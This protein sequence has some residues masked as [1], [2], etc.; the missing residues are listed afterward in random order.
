MPWFT[1]IETRI[2][3]F[4]QMIR[5]QQAVKAAQAPGAAALGFDEVISAINP[6]NNTVIP[7][8]ATTQWHTRLCDTCERNEQLVLTDRA[9]NDKTVTELNQAG[10][11]W[12]LEHEP[13]PPPPLPVA[14][15]APLPPIVVGWPYS[16]CIC[17]GQLAGPHGNQF[18]VRCCADKACSDHDERLIIRQ[19]N[20]AW[21]RSITLVGDEIRRAPPALRARR[22][23]HRIFRACRCGR[24]IRF[25][26]IDGNQPDVDKGP[27]VTQC[28]GCEGIVH[29]GPHVLMHQSPVAVLGLTITRRM[30]DAIDRA[31]SGIVDYPLR[32]VAV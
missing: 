28:L 8:A 18:C 31:N 2:N 21:L 5:S 15:G 17:S 1:A 13:N 26:S 16:T 20:D 24:E 30:Q 9:E 14:P 29:H 7:A 22:V 11:L 19:Q 32:R 23:Q 25:R 27:K 12:M 6:V 3:G 10:A 4:P